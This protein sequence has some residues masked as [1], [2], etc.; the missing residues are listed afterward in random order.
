MQGISSYNGYSQRV[1][2]GIKTSGSLQKLKPVFNGPTHIPL[3][4]PKPPSNKP[5]TRPLTKLKPVFNRPT[6]I[7]LTKPKPPSCHISKTFNK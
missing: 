5:S 1:S 2:F 6:H 4:V 7:P 3:I